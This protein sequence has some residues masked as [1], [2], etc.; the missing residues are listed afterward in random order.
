MATHTLSIKTE[1]ATGLL[2]LLF[3]KRLRNLCSGSP[4]TS[5]LS[6]LFSTAVTTLLVVERLPSPC[7]SAELHGSR[8]SS[9]LLSPAPSSDTCAG[10]QKGLA[11]AG[12]ALPGW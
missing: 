5:V 8:D 4:A 7:W 12:E 1:S 3:G 10:V 2:L 9:V 11:R 6:A